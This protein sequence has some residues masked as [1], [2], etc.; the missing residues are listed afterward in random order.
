MLEQA[1]TND[2]II[3]HVAKIIALLSPRAFGKLDMAWKVKRLTTQKE[4]IIYKEKWMNSILAY[5]EKS[6]KD[7]ST[8]AVLETLLVLRNVGGNISLVLQQKVSYPNQKKAV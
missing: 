3:I 5:F 6:T 7:A 8:F 4:I 1:P 2:T